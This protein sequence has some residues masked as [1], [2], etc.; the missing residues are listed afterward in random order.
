MALVITLTRVILAKSTSQ[1]PSKDHVYVMAPSLDICAVQAETDRQTTVTV[2][3]RVKHKTHL[4]LAKL[5]T[6]R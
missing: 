4:F 6:Y 1:N 5:T 2:L 3:Q